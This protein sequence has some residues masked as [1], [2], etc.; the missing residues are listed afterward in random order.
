MQC[1]SAL[2]CIA[3]AGK[4]WGAGLHFVES[5][6]VGLGRLLSVRLKLQGIA[7]VGIVIHALFC[8]TD[9]LLQITPLSQTSF[10]R[11]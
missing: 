6:T 8:R 5:G 4:D 11:L 3:P 10:D 7:D 2:N 9:E 1:D